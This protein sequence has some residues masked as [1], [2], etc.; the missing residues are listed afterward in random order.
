MDCRRANIANICGWF[1]R[2][3]RPRNIRSRKCDLLRLLAEQMVRIGE[4]FG[5]AIRRKRIVVTTDRP[6]AI[7]QHK[8]RAVNRTA[9]RFL[10][11]GEPELESITRNGSDR[12]ARAGE[13]IPAKRFLP[14]LVRISAQHRRRIFFRMDAKRTAMDI[15]LFQRLLQFAPPSADDR[16]RA[17]TGRG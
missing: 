11:L 9:V 1:A 13:K 4:Q 6:A 5:D 16:A 10:A 7:D 3:A 8:A 15:A 17:W 14:Q 12:I 2:K